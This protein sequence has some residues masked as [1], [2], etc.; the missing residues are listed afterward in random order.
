MK[1]TALLVVGC[2]A[3]ALGT[4]LALRGCGG[5][6]GGQQLVKWNEQPRGTLSFEVT[7]DTLPWNESV[8]YTVTERGV[9]QTAQ[10]QF[11]RRDRT[12]S[13]ADVRRG[14]TWT[15]RSETDPA[16]PAER[17]MLWY[18]ER[19]GEARGVAETI[20]LTLPGRAEIRLTGRPDSERRDDIT[21][22]HETTG[23]YGCVIRDPVAGTLQRIWNDAEKAGHYYIKRR[24]TKRPFRFDDFAPGDYVVAARTEGHHWIARRVELVAGKTLELDT[25]GAPE[26][27]CRVVCDDPGGVL[28]LGGDL[29]I[30][31]PRETEVNYRATWDGVPTGRHAMLYPDGT[32]MEFTCSEAA[33]TV[34]PRTKT[35]PK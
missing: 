5:G 11:L 9:P 24:N 20:T 1:T 2:A 32:R 13:I 27:G 12:F 30:P 10:L 8:Y 34:L 29:P 18:F 17:R 19:K 22:A 7:G 31:D 14:E 6:G 28:L 25:E 4:A 23:T 35:P 33:E 15:V 3:A 21:L 26:G 16:S